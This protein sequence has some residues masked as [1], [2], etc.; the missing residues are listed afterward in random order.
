MDNSFKLTIPANGIN[1]KFSRAIVASFAVPCSPTLEEINDLKTAVSEAVTNCVVHAY[2]NGGE[3]EIYGQLDIAERSVTLTVTDFGRGIADVSAAKEP[4]YTTRAD[5]ERSGM[6]FTIIETFT[7]EMSVTS[8][9]GKG[10][11]VKM[12]KVFR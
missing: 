12:K 10:T 2:D 9:V 5:E 3:I 8:E 11:S 6:G 7:D 1:E 4:F